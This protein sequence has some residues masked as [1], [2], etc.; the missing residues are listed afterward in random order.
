VIT[1]LTTI[2]S[3][4]P[5]DCADTCSILSHVENGKLV[6]I[7]GNPAHPVTQGFICRKVAKL[8]ERIYGPERLLYPLRRVGPK[9]SGQ[10]ERISWEEAISIIAGRWK[11][12]MAEHSPHSILPF[13]GSGTEG[14]VQGDVVGK[15]F[16]NRLGTIQLIRTICTKAGRTGFRHTMGASVGGDPTNLAGAKMVIAWG[17]NAGSTNIHQQTFF[18]QARANGALF[19][20][21]N[22][23]RIKDCGEMALQ[24]R[25]G[26]DAA[27]ALGMMHVIVEE[28]LYDKE[29]VAKG[30][31]GFEALCERLKEYPP[32]RVAEITGIEAEAIKDFARAYATNKPSFIYVGPGCQRHSNGGMTLRTITCLPALVGAWKHPS[33]GFYF[34][35]STVFPV[36][37]HPLEG[38][39]LRPNPVVGYNMINLG[40]LLTEPNFAIQSLYVYCGNPAAVLY[41]QTRVRQGL[42]R[43][44]LFT[45]V[46][47]LFM[48]DTA[49]YADILLPATSQF[50][51][52]DLLYSYYSPSLLLNNPAIEPLGESRS[53]LRVFADLAAAMGFED[54]CFK[55]NEWDIIDQL[56]ALDEP[57]IK[58]ITLEQLK[59]DG[60]AQANPDPVQ[61][62]YAEGRFPT[63]SGKAEFYSHSMEADGFDPL[64]A[65]V[66]PRESPDAT[67]ELFKRHPLCFITPSGHSF[68]NAAYGDM[69]GALA[70][71][72]RPTLL[73][74]PN[75]AER[76][77]LE[78]G[79]LVEVFNDRGSCQLW[80]K[81]DAAVKSGVVAS[82]GQ[83]WSCHYPD[84]GNANFTTPD[85][86]SEMGGG[87][88]FNSNLVEV[89]KVKGS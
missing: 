3:V 73:I 87:S 11:A 6:R 57:A 13:C 45:V 70:S 59:K 78:D 52:P 28:G 89:R 76:R 71:E 65:Y 51:H 82:Q 54:P 16:F 22:P 30:T 81:I 19:A 64:P 33:G 79:D 15:R 60:W 84:G 44:D 53:N 56:L 12:I 32:E 7:E 48:T 55:E 41:D 8:P 2:H 58:G 67:P 49:R 20:T 85:F 47:E 14:L 46:H 29:F 66:P 37:W 83:W 50:E 25:P 23:I 63:K 43:E 69:E 40:R 18:K 24:P 88:A 21:V 1:K 80:A 72:K 38:D 34:P 17:L 36:D 74:H 75:D 35:T 68:L 26:T 61:A 86:V 39:E 27:L 62:G 4:C 9:G 42:A 10:F 77:G 5:H 31:F